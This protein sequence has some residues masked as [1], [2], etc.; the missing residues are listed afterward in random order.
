MVSW[1]LRRL[2][3]TRV[4]VARSRDRLVALETPVWRALEASVWVGGR[5]AAQRSLLRPAKVGLGRERNPGMR[6]AQ[7]AE[8]P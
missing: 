6:L 5:H 8:M 2:Q 3:T 1:P 7:C 4:G